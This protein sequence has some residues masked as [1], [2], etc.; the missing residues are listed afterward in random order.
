[1]TPRKLSPH[2]K[3][4]VVSPAHHLELKVSVQQG[5]VRNHR[6]NYKEKKSSLFTPI[7]ITLSLSL[8]LNSMRS[9]HVSL[10][11]ALT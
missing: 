3:R 9:L 2:L 5:L 6:G 10:N 1:M 4:C 11:L 7:I 8:F